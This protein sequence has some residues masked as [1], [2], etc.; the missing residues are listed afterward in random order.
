MMISGNK[1]YNTGLK[2]WCKRME[3]QDL[4]QVGNDKLTLTVAL[5]FSL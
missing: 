3:F 5:L 1:V 4:G 2:N